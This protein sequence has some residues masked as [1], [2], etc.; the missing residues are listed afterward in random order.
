MKM[1][2]AADA[3]DGKHYL[4]FTNDVPGRMSRAL[5]GFAVDGKKSAN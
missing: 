5:Q 4:T 2:E 3:P 1:V